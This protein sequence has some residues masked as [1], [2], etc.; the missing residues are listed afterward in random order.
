[1]QGTKIQLKIQGQKEQELET[2]DKLGLNRFK[3]KECRRNTRTITNRRTR[4]S[5]IDLWLAQIR[6]TTSI[7]FPNR[8]TQRIARSK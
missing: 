3:A 1:M 6:R 2:Q 5:R 4:L 7:Q 8:N